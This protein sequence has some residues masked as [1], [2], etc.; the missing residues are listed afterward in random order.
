MPD[1]CREVGK[2]EMLAKRIG[3]HSGVGASSFKI[4]RIDGTPSLRVDAED[5]DDREISEAGMNGPCLD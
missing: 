4:S 3:F 2:A 5:D 1:L